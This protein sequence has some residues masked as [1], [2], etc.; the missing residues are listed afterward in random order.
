MLRLLQLLQEQV[1]GN[2]SNLHVPLRAKALTCQPVLLVLLVR[3]QSTKGLVL[4]HVNVILQLVLPNRKVLRRVIGQG[5]TV[6]ARV[7]V[8]VAK[9]T[10]IAAKA[11]ATDAREIV[12]V[13]KEYVIGGKATVIV[14][15]VIVPI[16]IAP[17]EIVVMIAVHAVLI[18]PLC[19]GGMNHVIIDEQI[20]GR[21]E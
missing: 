7:T 4:Q 15:I 12:I 11:S 13:A 21:S 6:I 19:Q 20:Y 10:E 3:R 8:T 18:A 16:V 17:I 2:A 9:A 1:L 14:L 5:A